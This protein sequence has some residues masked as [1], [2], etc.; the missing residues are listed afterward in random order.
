MRRKI[1]RLARRA[2]AA[3]PARPGG[4]LVLMYHRV[5]ELP[6]DPWRLGVRPGHFQEHLDIIA[7]HLRPITAAGLSA[8]LEEGRIAPRTVVVTMDDGYADLAMT[9]RPLLEAAGVPA[10]MF[11]VSGAIDDPREFWWDALERALLGERPVPPTLTLEIDGREV[12]W[13]IDATTRE[14]AYRSV[15][16]ALRPLPTAERDALMTEVATWAG[17]PTQARSTH[18]SLRSDEL[19]ELA[20]DG[21][22]EIGGHTATHPSLGSLPAADQEREIEDGR[23][24][25]EARI[26]RRITSL[27]YPFGRDPD[28][29]AET[30]AAARRSRFSAAFTT[31]EGRVRIGDDPHALRRVFV[32]D[33]DGEGFARLLRRVAGLRVG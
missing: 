31:D 32:D 7:R 22:V 24:E 4:A 16:A 3:I 26:D 13:D 2:R 18:R 29:T 8:R 28:V 20:R 9:A 10:T 12:S 30:V 27:A 6:V 11:I 17:Q 21:L 15:W 14:R 1:R 25:L 5:A 33:L 23:R 19:A